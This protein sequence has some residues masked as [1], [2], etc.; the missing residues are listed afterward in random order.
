[1]G[2]GGEIHRSGPQIWGPGGRGST[3]RPRSPATKDRSP[4]Q[5]PPNP[6]T[7]TGA[8][9][10][11]CPR[12]RALRLP[13]ARLVPSGSAYLGAP[14]PAAEAGGKL[15]RPA[16]E[17]RRGGRRR[18]AARVRA[19]AR[20]WMYAPVCL[21]RHRAGGVLR[22]VRLLQSR[23]PHAAARSRERLTGGCVAPTLVEPPSSDPCAPHPPRETRAHAAGARG[24]G[25]GTEPVRLAEG[26]ELGVARWC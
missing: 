4:S 12:P 25:V 8:L 13:Q 22:A 7:P 14:A 19:V 24:A 10:A 3:R 15:P 11:R 26:P 16:G 18:L 9:L 20:M 21:P 17:H 1:M 5:P 23:A 2:G 6:P